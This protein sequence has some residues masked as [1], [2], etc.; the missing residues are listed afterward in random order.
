WVRERLPLL[1]AQDGSLLAAGDVVLADGFQR[2]LAEAG[3][4]LRWRCP[5]H[6]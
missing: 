4:K 3:L 2:Q 6:A 5:D 1:C